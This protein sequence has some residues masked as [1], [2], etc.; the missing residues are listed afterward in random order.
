MDKPALLLAFL[1]EQLKD[2]KKTRVRQLLQHG[3]ISVSG[4]VTTQFNH[5]LQ[6]GDEV[7]IGASQPQDEECDLPILYEDDDLIAISKPIGLL[8]IATDTIRD[9]TAI[10]IVNNHVSRQAGQKSSR[11]S[12]PKEYFYSPPPRPRCFWGDAIR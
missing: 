2:S 9:K 3:C 11:T 8:S 10:A 6:S 7:C 1:F 4:Q 5:A 12:L